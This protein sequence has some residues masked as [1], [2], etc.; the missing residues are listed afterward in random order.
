MRHKETQ[1]DWLR[2]WQTA[3]TGV[4]LSEWIHLYECFH[5]ESLTAKNICASSLFYYQDWKGKQTIFHF[6]CLFSKADNSLIH[7]CASWSEIGVCIESV[8]SK[9]RWGRWANFVLPASRRSCVP[10]CAQ[11]H[12]QV[13]LHSAWLYALF[14]SFCAKVISDYV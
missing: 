5:L 11:L 14:V 3:H 9:L 2:D 10:L 8:C 13:G 6:G 7:F 12:K 1:S 4:I